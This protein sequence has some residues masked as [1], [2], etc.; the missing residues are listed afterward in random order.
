MEKMIT[1]DVLVGK[2]VIL[3]PCTEEFVTQDYVDWMNKTEV[4]QYLETR[5]V[6]QTFDMVK[7]Y[8][9]HNINAEN[10]ML[11]AIISKEDGVHVGNLHLTFVQRHKR[12]IFAYAIGKEEYWGHGIMSEA[13]SLATRWVF[14]N[15]DVARL[16]AGLYARNKGSLRA[17]EKAGWKKEAVCRSFFLLNDGTR[18]D[19]ILVGILREDFEE[20]YNGK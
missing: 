3:K 5:Y 18:D 4:N 17:L 13:I 19:E 15:F 20:I 9:L 8:V 2:S 6:E 14:E 11:L 16:D 7:D 12:C 10:E 1:K